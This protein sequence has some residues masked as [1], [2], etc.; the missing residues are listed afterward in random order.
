MRS[1]KNSPGGFNSKAALGEE[2][3]HEW[4]RVREGNNETES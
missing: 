1:N 2:R 3:E 4:R